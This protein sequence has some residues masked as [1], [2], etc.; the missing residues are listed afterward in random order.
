MAEVLAVGE[1]TKSEPTPAAKS[2][3]NPLFDDEG[4][5][6][7]VKHANTITMQVLLFLLQCIAF[8]LFICNVFVLSASIV[9]S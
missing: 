8:S 1:E 7:A 6:D 5:S 4:M 2:F 3:E 9:R